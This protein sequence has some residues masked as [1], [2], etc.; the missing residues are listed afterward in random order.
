MIKPE[1][2]DENGVTRRIYTGAKKVLSAEIIEKGLYW[3]D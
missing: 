2:R 3:N 1:I